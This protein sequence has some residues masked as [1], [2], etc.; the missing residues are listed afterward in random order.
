MAV[1]TQRI[2]IAALTRIRAQTHHAG[3]WHLLVQVDGMEPSLLMVVPDT[4]DVITH[5][6]RLSSQSRDDTC[7]LIVKAGETKALVTFRG[8]LRHT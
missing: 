1:H 4:E 5:A 2:H 8:L 3:P 7:Y 6:Y